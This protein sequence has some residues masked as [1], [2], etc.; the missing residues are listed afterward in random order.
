MCCGSCMYMDPFSNLDLASLKILHQKAA[1][2]LQ[3]RLL[4]GALWHE[5]KEQTALVTRLAIQ[6]H[7]RVEIEESSGIDPS[8]AG[9]PPI[10]AQ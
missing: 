10:Q 6:I 2:E 5:L 7:K 4:N 9:N 1:A 8:T 3:E